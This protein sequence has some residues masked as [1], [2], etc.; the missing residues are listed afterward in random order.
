VPFDVPTLCCLWNG[1][2]TWWEMNKHESQ[3]PSVNFSERYGESSWIWRGKCAHP[4]RIGPELC[5]IWGIFQPL[6]RAQSQI[7]EGL[8]AYSLASTGWDS[9]RQ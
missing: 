5:M 6:K 7:M 8:P 2:W 4:T 1:S 3:V 9:T